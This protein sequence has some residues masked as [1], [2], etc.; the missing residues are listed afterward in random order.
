VGHEGNKGTIVQL[1]GLKK[2]DVVL[3]NP[4]FTN[5]HRFVKTVFPDISLSALLF[6]FYSCLIDMLSLDITRS[7]HLQR[8]SRRIPSFTGQSMTLRQVKRNVGICFLENSDL[9]LE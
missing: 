1:G 2:A 6:F 3:V 7:Q 5:G 4:S 8:Y 9:L